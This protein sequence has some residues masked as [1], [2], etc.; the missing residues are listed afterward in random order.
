MRV[1]R[2]L[3][4]RGAPRPES[5]RLV[6]IQHGVLKLGMSVVDLA[7][8]VRNFIRALAL[9]PS[10]GGVSSRPYVA[11]GGGNMSVLCWRQ[12]SQHLFKGNTSRRVGCHGIY[13]IKKLPLLAPRRK[14]TDGGR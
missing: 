7:L 5:P 10:D 2:A 3:G 11:T 14:V 6:D 1:V 13:V 4:A 9:I 8:A 12:L